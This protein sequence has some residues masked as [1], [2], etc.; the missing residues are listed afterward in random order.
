MVRRDGAA[1]YTCGRR[2]C[3]LWLSI[4]N[5]LPTYR[6]YLHIKY[7]TYISYVTWYKC[8]NILVVYIRRRDWR[9]RRK[10]MQQT[11][12]HTTL[13]QTLANYTFGCV[14]LVLLWRM[15]NIIIYNIVNSLETLVPSLAYLGGVLLCPH[16]IF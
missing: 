11:K 16:T 3:I 12:M 9:R 6:T 13:Q 14:L 1:V 7:G 2:A 5:T 15:T 4:K 10:K 8:N